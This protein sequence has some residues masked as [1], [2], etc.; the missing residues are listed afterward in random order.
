MAGDPYAECL[1]PA[2]TV[3]PEGESEFM[4]AVVVVTEETPKGTARSPQEYVNP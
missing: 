4:R 2:V 1:P 3:D